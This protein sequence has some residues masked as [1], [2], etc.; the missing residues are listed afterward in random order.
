MWSRPALDRGIV[1]AARGDGAAF[2][3][4]ERDFAA[5][6]ARYQDKTKRNTQVEGGVLVHP[7]AVI[8][9]KRKKLCRL[10]RTER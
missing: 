9:A 3:K 2:A 5:G 4:K 7:H 6:L 8:H 10:I 1:D